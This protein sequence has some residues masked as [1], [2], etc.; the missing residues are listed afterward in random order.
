MMSGSGSSGWHKNS[1]YKNNHNSSR[2]GRRPYRGGN[3]RNRRSSSRRGGFKGENLPRS[4]FISEPKTTE[5]VVQKYE[6]KKFI[7][8]GLNYQ[9]VENLGQKNFTTT[10]EIQERTIAKIIEGKDVLGISSTGSGKTGA[11]LIP[12]VEKL[13]QDGSQKLLIV[14]PT[15]ELALQIMKEA[16]SLIK[17]TD[18]QLALVIGGASMGRQI[19]QLR[20]GGDIIVGTPGRL[21]DL[22]KRNIV[23]LNDYNNIVVDEVDKMLDMGFIEDIR[24]VFE[25]LNEEKQ[26]LFFSATLNEKVQKIVE[27]FCSS[28][29][30]VR[31]AENKP[32]ENVEQKVI[33]YSDREEKMILLKELLDKDEVEKVL[34]F[35]ETKRYA[36]KV[37]RTL[38]E[39]NFRV[40]AIHGDKRQRAREKVIKLFRYSDINILVATNVA[41]RGIDINDITHV[42]NLDQPQNYDEYIHR[43]GRTGRNGKTGTAYTFYPTGNM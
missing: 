39:S 14:A 37:E 34:I 10:T 27:S 13:L 29:E 22:T 41:A 6:G 32:S 11:F 43:I 21:K 1:P 36:D 31:L 19:S 33:D 42:I 28:F 25:Q 16:I 35:V 7:D 38:Y 8:Y 4:M 3:S 12:M 15:R 40:G 2:R 20:R 18:L 9:I 23:N 24:T 26:S 30:L 17:G 5:I